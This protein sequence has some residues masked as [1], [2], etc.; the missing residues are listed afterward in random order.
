MHVQVYDPGNE[1]KT[2]DIDRF[3]GKSGI[4]FGK[5]VGNSTAGHGD[6]HDR[7]PVIDRIHHRGAF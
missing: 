3:I 7:M 5:D 1:I 4:H 2:A 6:I